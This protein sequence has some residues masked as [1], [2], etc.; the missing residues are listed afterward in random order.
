MVWQSA[1]RAPPAVHNFGLAAAGKERLAL[2]QFDQNAPETPHVDGVRVGHAEIILGMPYS[3]AIDM[4]SLGCILVELHQGEALFAGRSEAEIVHGWWGTLGRLPDHLIEASAKQQRFFSLRRFEP[5]GP[6]FQ[7]RGSGATGASLELLLADVR[8]RRSGEP[9]HT[10]ADYANF[11]DLV[12]R[13]LTYDVAQR[14]TPRH[15]LEHR[16]FGPQ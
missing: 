12:T 13:M 2:M 16:F 8:R 4:W 7:L 1:E 6:K 9:G 5:S 3:H 14:L 10:P 11:L 15:A